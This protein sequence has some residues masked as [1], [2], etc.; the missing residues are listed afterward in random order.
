[1]R[2]VVI[3]VETANGS[4]ASM[5]QWAAGRFDDD[6]RIVTVS[7]LV[8]PGPK[9]RF[10]A[11]NV[12]VHG[13]EPAAVATAPVPPAM[14][15]LVTASFAWADVIACH[16]APFDDSVMRAVADEWGLVLPPTPVACTLRLARR[17]WPDAPSHSLGKLTAWLGLPA[18][19]HHDAEADVTATCRLIEA[20]AERLGCHVSGVF[21]AAGVAPRVSA[22]AA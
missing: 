4:R 10:A 8:N 12:A 7:R 3:D 22:P 11:G 15:D 14:W 17:V 2:I 21:D 18:F 6:G 19:A 5:C 16:N 13:I 20:A 9:V 1:V